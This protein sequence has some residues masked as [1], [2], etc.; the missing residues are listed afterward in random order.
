[1]ICLINSVELN[2]IETQV[3][4]EKNVYVYNVN[5]GH[6]GVSHNQLHSLPRPPPCTHT[7]CLQHVGKG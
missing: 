7:P 5:G 6:S 4:S 3:A 1:M 2:V